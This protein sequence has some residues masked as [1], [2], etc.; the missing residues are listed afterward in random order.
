MLH[1]AIINTV[2]QLVIALLLVV[3]HVLVLRVRATHTTDCL[4]FSRS[5]DIL[6]QNISAICRLSHWLTMSTLSFD[7]ALTQIA[8]HVDAI[9]VAWDG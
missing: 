7:L 5:Y 3:V 8:I 6:N 4:L 1:L 9:L 2:S